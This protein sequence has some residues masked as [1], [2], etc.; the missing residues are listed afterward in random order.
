MIQKLKRYIQKALG[1]G[2]GYEDLLRNARE[3]VN[4]SQSYNLKDI[5]RVHGTPFTIVK[6]PT[7]EQEQN[8]FIAIG[9][10]RVTEM[11]TGRE[12]MNMILN[13]D[14]NLIVSAIDIIASNLQ[15]MKPV[16]EVPEEQE[17]A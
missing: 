10:S 3:R 12:C 5:E 17:I 9:N 11:K 1:K 15:N 16:K 6:V 7:I 13:K 14:W 2:K 8:S 4:S